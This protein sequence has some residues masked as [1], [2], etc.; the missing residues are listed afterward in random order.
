[1]LI[2]GGAPGGHV[3][4]P[5]TAVI[6]PQKCGRWH[7]QNADEREKTA[8]ARPVE[9]KNAVHWARDR[10]AMSIRLFRCLQKERN[11]P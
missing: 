9:L 11:A 6:F 5:P 2:S 8:K 1:M 4:W 7:F 3:K 10:L